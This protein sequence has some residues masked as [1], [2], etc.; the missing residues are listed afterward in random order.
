MG[1]TGAWVVRV[2]VTLGLLAL[3]VLSLPLVAIVFDGE[4]QEGWIIPVQVVLMALVGAGVGLLVPTLAGEGA[5]R[6]RSAVVGA[7]IALVGVAVGLVLF[8]LLLNG[9]DGL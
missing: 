1:S 5:S 3:G 7:V 2:V 9:L 4:G 8:F 6:T